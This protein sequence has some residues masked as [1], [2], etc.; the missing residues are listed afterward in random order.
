MMSLAFGFTLVSKK[1]V[2]L[3]DFLPPGKL[4]INENTGR[5]GTFLESDATSGTRR[6]GKMSW[7]KNL[8]LS[9]Y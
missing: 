2:L 6:Q 7:N 5:T 3:F 1:E 9:F 4:E 8:N